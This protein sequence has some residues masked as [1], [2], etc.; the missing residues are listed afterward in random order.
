MSRFRKTMIA[1]GLALAAAVAPSA[2][3]FA[4]SAPKP[5]FVEVIGVVRQVDDSRALVH[6]KYRCTGDPHVWVSVKQTADRKADPRLA[7]EGSSQI[8][9]AWSQ[10]HEA[11]LDCDGRVHVDKFLV[12]QDEVPEGATEPVG[13]GVLERGKAWVQ[14]C[15]VD[16]ASGAILTMDNEFRKLL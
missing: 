1:A 16:T 8:A 13:F 9:A 15:L 2:P 3:A 7:Q 6:A 10:T 12:H 14:F 11:D 5:S 4:H